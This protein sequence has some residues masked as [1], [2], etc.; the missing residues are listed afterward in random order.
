MSQNW[1]LNDKDYEEL[2]VGLGPIGWGVYY[3]CK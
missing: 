1:Q 2:Q 3:L